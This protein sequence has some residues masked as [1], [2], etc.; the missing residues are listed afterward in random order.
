MDYKSAKQKTNELNTK[1]GE[2]KFGRWRVACIAEIGGEK[3]WVPV[4]SH[5]WYQ[6]N[7]I[8]SKE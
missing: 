8:F 2:N 4:T 5:Y 3:I 1:Y 7:R 6:D